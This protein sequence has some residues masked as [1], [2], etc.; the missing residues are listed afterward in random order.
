MGKKLIRSYIAG[1]MVIGILQFADGLF[2]IF[3]EPTTVNISFSI[4]EAIWF[5]IT[6]GALFLFLQNSMSLVLPTSFM[7]YILFSFFLVASLF[8]KNDSITGYDIPYWMGIMESVFGI[9][10]CI[11]AFTCFR[12]IAK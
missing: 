10:Y 7:A 5:G 3:G 8:E 4:F 1:C 9:F 12:A 11:K 6:F 2:F